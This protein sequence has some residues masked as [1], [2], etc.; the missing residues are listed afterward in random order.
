MS[1]RFLPPLLLVFSATLVGASTARADGVPPSA[2]T[3]AQRHLAVTHF[4]RGKE[5]MSKARYEEAIAEF[6]SSHEIVASP[7]VSLQVARCLRAENRLVDAYEEFGRASLEAV[8]LASEKRYN[9]AFDAANEERAEIAPLLGFVTLRIGNPTEGTRVTIAGD[10]IRRSAWSEA[11]AVAPGTPEILVET[12]GHKPIKRELKIAA[13]A[14]IALEI[15]AQSGAPEA[16]EAPPRE[17][18]PPAQ[19]TGNTN[20]LWASYG[21]AGVGVTGLV[22]FTVAALVANSTFNDLKNTCGNARCPPSKASEISAGEGQQAVANVALV[23]GILGVAT[24]G[25]LFVLARPAP[26][27]VSQTAIAVWPGGVGVVGAWR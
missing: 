19:R 25:S 21:A 20:L 27:V 13:G 10:E 17:A 12:P 15:D 22:T 2:A 5:L 24:A 7:N 6:R 23:F 18:P 14:K 8:E 3:P 9:E 1:P 4:L 26:G 11:R 16:S